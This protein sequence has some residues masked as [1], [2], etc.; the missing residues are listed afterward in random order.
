MNRLRAAVIILLMYVA[1]RAHAAFPSKDVFLPVAG[2]VA[3]AFG[4]TIVPSQSSMRGYRM[5]ECCT[6]RRAAGN[7][8]NTMHPNPRC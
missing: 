6:R 4:S 2:R 5:V 3:G 8:T 7:A 1:V